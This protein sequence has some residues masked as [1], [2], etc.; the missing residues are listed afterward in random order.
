M[1][2]LLKCPTLI[3]QEN[4]RGKRK[5]RYIN[6][7]QEGMKQNTLEMAEISFGKEEND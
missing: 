2:K 7:E 1:K 5:I 6:E 3:N 4:V